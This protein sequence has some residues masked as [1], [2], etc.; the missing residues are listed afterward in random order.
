MEYFNL[1]RYCGYPL[2]VPDGTE[3]SGNVFFTCEND[4]YNDDDIVLHHDELCNLVDQIS[5]NT[6]FE[7]T[8]LPP[9]ELS[10]KAKAI[11]INDGDMGHTYE[12][13]IGDY[14][15]G[16]KE[17]LITE[18]YLFN[19]YQVRNLLEFV[20]FLKK[21]DGLR[22]I[23]LNTKKHFGNN[24]LALNDV[25]SRL[26][27][28]YNKGS[29]IDFFFEFIGDLHDRKIKTNTGWLI[30]LGRGLHFYKK[31]NNK[32]FDLKG[33]DYSLKECFETTITIVPIGNNNYT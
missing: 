1:C 3:E 15:F 30:H 5:F 14:L 32:N 9:G 21:I 31:R 33:Q 12:S 28:N 6:Q 22:L 29:G 19:R 7:N 23:K 13:L 11:E 17:L 18:T 25:L 24:Y 4:C 10:L 2:D 27:I 20:W 8:L 26:K 16:C